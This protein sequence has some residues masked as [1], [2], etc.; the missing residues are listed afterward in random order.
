MARDRFG[1]SER[2]A[3]GP[4][5]GSPSRLILTCGLPGAGKT[6]LARRLAVEHGAVRL[7]KDEWQWA[8]RG[9]SRAFAP[10]R[11]TRAVD[12]GHH[13]GTGAEVSGFLDDAI[14]RAIRSPMGCPSLASGR[15][16]PA[17]AYQPSRLA[18]SQMCTVPSLLAEAM[19]PSV[20]ST[21]AFTVSVWPV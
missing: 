15:P 4:T 10:G 11:R 14:R 21:S 6:T 13:A 12:P 3:P 7:T 20:S 9:S 16:A 8:H 17:L 18:G 2:I 19:R 1:V 5:I